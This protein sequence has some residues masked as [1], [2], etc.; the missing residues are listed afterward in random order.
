MSELRLLTASTQTGATG[1]GPGRPG[2]PGLRVPAGTPG[3]AVPLRWAWAGGGTR[4]LEKLGYLKDHPQIA[5]SAW[6]EL[7]D[8]SLKGEDPRLLFPY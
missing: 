7:L 5:P 2:A 3:G 8:G 4:F 6:K 1:G